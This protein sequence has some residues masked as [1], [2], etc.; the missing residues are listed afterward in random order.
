MWGGGRGASRGA[1]P[2]LNNRA[3][4][5]PARSPTLNPRPSSP[6]PPP[7]SALLPHREEGRAP[8]VGG[9][10]LVPGQGVGP[11]RVQAV[12][13]EERRRLRGQPEALCA[14]QPRGDRGA[15]RAALHA[16]RGRADCGQRLAHRARGRA[17]QG[18]VPEEGRVCQHQG[19]QR[20]GGAGVALGTCVCV[21]A[22]GEGA[23]GRHP[24]CGV[25]PYGP[26]RP[27]PPSTA[28]PRPPHPCPRR[29]RC[30]STTLP[31]RAAS[32]RTSSPSWACPSPRWSS[33]P[34]T[35]VRCAARCAALRC[36]LR[37]TGLCCVAALSP[38]PRPLPCPPP[39]HQ[40]SIPHLI[41]AGYPK[42]F[43]AA[44]PADESSKLPEV[45]PG[46][47]FKKLNWLK[48]GILACDKLLTVSP[49]YA[50]GACR[51]GG[52][53]RG[54]GALEELPASLPAAALAAACLALRRRCPAAHAAP[55]TCALPSLLP[56]PL[57]D[58]QRPAAGC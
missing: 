4:A 37:A 12:R 15:A 41:P 18:G 6:A 23:A 39:V 51:A 50:T 31:S 24:A 35:T 27:A 22:C 28:H 48:A 56:A 20:G 30:A 45:A 33:S 46:V 19:E 8:R 3:R 52:A 58:C 42:V 21:C 5:A 13:R 57:R 2:R 7:C 10:P 49:N 32:G 55:L 26:H 11:D 1:L 17:A 54:G 14:V 44:S 25:C 47:S 16:G 34:S 43:D 29:P 40:P 36:G 9:P 53:A 38:R